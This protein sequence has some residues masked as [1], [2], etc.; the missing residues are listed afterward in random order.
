MTLE[1]G[2]ISR[3]GLILVVLQFIS[4]SHTHAK[5]ASKFK[6]NAHRIEIVSNLPGLSL[7]LDPRTD[8]LAPP[9]LEA[10]LST[11]ALTSTSW[12]ALEVNLSLLAMPETVFELKLASRLYPF[13]RKTSGIVVAEHLY[14]R[15][16][17]HAQAVLNNS[18]LGPN[19]EIGIAPSLGRISFLLG[20][21]SAYYVRQPR[22]VLEFRGGVGV[23]F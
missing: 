14:V 1:P 15:F 10:R 8:N 9:L 5:E 22:V 12:M 23:L 4:P 6:R 21:S 11:H 3:L 7:G 13:R 19:F 17:V 16:G 18:D 20:V 2:L